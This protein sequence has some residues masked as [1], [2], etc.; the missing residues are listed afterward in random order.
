MPI[1]VVLNNA[2]TSLC[3][4]SLRPLIGHRRN[5]GLKRIKWPGL[6]MKFRFQ[7]SITPI[8]RNSLYLHPRSLKDLS[9]LSGQCKSPLALRLE[10]RIRQL[11]HAPDI[12]APLAKLCLPKGHYGVIITPETETPV[13]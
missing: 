1:R 12:R 5:T 6:T 3:S 7:R 4:Q 8:L 10:L 2:C 11:Q 9:E 13:P